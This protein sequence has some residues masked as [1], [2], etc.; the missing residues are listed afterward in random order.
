[1]SMKS[2]VFHFFIFPPIRTT[3][4]KPPICVCS[5]ACL[6]ACSTYHQVP[7]F[8]YQLFSRFLIANKCITKSERN[9]QLRGT[10]GV[11]RTSAPIS[12]GNSQK[13]TVV[14]EMHS[15][16]HTHTQ[17]ASWRR[18]SRV[19]GALKLALGLLSWRGRGRTGLST[20]RQQVPRPL[21]CRGRLATA[22][23]IVCASTLVLSGSSSLLL[24]HLVAVF[25][26]VVIVRVHH[27]SVNHHVADD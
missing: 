8:S 13:L 9:K 14:F 16:H 5:Y 19:V 7:Y 21:R 15:L 6:L 18:R 24:F 20:R 10:W 22:G 3:Y 12:T 27:R 2:L 25:I 26:L 1:M 4:Q 23:E 17:D 11:E